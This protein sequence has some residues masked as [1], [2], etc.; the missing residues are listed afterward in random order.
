LPG[1][2]LIFN[3]EVEYRRKPLDCQG[4]YIACE[5]GNPNT[6]ADQRVS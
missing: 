3:H 5:G 6:A 2:N 4:G 1:G